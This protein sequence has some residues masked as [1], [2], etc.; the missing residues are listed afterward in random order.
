MST[1]KHINIKPINKKISSTLSPST[2]P[3]EAENNKTFTA[4]GF[5][6]VEL[7]L[8]IVIIGILAAITIVAY[9]GV[10]NRA[11]I[12]SIQSDLTT[13]SQQLKM[14]YAE[15]GFYPTS[16]D[17]NKCPKDSSNNV[18][19]NYCLKASSGNSYQY[20]SSTSP[21]TFCITATNG[22]T[23]YNITPDY[24]ALAGPCPVLRLDAG[25]SIS[26]SGTGTTWYDLSGNGNNGTISSTGVTYSSTNGGALSFD[27][28]SGYVNTNYVSSIT[29]NQIT[30]SAWI[31]PLNISGSHEI[32]NQGQWD[33]SPWTGWR[34]SHGS[35]VSF[36]IGDG[37]STEY[38]CTGGNL[39]VNN[40]YYVVGT[41]DGGYIRIYVN[42]AEASNCAKS[43]TYSGNTS[44]HSIGKYAGSAYFFN[45]LIGNIS[46]YNK[47][48]SVSDVL[49]NFN[50]TRSRYSI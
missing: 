26:Y 39:V 17:S 2:K 19:T 22:S 43:F 42:G 18:D 25:N 41:W 9:T 4:I 49:Q 35:S 13:A 27:G 33:G 20:I 14:Y 11:N 31:K 21:Q 48:L 47:S 45:G 36:K 23:S 15:H 3:I 24:A 7:L 38:S 37:S 1:I 44:A 34:F 16:L 12:A 50:T 30:V 28:S 5:T 29:S 40:W 6:I 32:S 10:T 46:I 8:V